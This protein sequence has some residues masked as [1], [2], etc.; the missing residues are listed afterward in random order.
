M[1]PQDFGQAGKTRLISQ[2]REVRVYAKMY[3]MPGSRAGKQ[4]N[5]DGP[6]ENQGCYRLATPKKPHRHSLLPRLHRILPI[7]YS[8]LF[9][10]RTT[11]LGFNKESDAM[12]LDG[13][14]NKSL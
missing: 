3:R 13:N 2:T 10:R 7:L 12:D 9:T 14:P 1:R 5:P 8:K 11:P 4:H 6:N